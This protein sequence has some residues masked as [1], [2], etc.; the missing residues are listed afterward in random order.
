MQTANKCLIITEQ[1]E[2]V[3]TNKNGAIPYTLDF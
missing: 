3:E 1:M 2:L